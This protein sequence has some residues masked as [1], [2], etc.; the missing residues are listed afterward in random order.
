ML[1]QFQ[2]PTTYKW[3]GK[4]RR[5][6]IPKNREKTDTSQKKFA[7]VPDSSR[8]PPTPGLPIHI[9]NNHCRPQTIIIIHPGCHF[10]PNK[11]V[12]R[13]LKHMGK[14]NYSMQRVAVAPIWVWE[15]TTAE[16]KWA[17][18]QRRLKRRRRKNLVG[19]AQQNLPFVSVVRT[20]C[21]E[22][23]P[24]ECSHGF[25]IRV[26]IH[27]TFT[28]SS[29]WWFECWI[30]LHLQNHWLVSSSTESGKQKSVHTSQICT[31]ASLQL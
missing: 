14:H 16:K 10:T 7:P 20:L 17:L 6:H 11:T 13:E 21:F 15:H 27:V 28:H 4:K 1:L 18:D 24:L 22:K 23:A 9:L 29:T 2:I 25:F 5:A 12:K 26:V 8:F 19:T 31:A 30:L 3:T